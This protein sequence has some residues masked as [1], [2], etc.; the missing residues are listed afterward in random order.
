MPSSWRTVSILAM[1]LSLLP[2]DAEGKAMEGKVLVPISFMSNQLFDH[3]I[4]K[5]HE[6]PTPDSNPFIEAINQEARKEYQLNHPTWKEFTQ[7][8]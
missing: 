7:F 6:L 3:D 4:K 2:V 1:L 8:Q 5:H